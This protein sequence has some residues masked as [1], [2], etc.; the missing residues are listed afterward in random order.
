[1]SNC[2]GFYCDILTK[3]YMGEVKCINKKEIV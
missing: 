2:V 1:M 3:S